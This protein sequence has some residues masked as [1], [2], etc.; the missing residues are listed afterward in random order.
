[1][2]TTTGDPGP[3]PERAVPPV[4]EL[5]VTEKFVIADPP[6]GPGVNDTDTDVDV[7]VGVSVAVTPVGFPGTFFTAKADDGAE[8][9]PVPIA[10]L[11]RTWHV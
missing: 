11:A 4:L 7:G 5:H 2:A 3:D 6:L 8:N 1:M 10:L 9:P